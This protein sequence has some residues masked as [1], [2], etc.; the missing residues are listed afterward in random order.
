[1]PTSIRTTSQFPLSLGF[2]A[3]AWMV[4]I[5]VSRFFACWGYEAAIHADPF[6][7]SKREGNYS[8]A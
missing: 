7:T 2:V 8:N 5:E 1:M 3:K 4:G 6:Y